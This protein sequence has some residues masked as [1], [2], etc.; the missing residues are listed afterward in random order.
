MKSINV[1]R[2][3]YVERLEDIRNTADAIF[4]ARPKAKK[5]FGRPRYRRKDNIEMVYT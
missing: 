2:T 1:I 5:P 3:M 4:V